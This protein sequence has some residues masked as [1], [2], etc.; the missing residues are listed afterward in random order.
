LSL[1]EERNWNHDRPEDRCKYLPRHFR[2][3]R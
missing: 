3:A 2:P 1:R